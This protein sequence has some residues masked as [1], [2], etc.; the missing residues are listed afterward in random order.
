MTESILP[1]RRWRE[2]V[3]SASKGDVTEFVMSCPALA[4]IQRSV[5]L[6]I[7]SQKS[8]P[9]LVHL[10]ALHT[11]SLYA[12]AMRVLAVN[13]PAECVDSFDGYLEWATSRDLLHNLI[14]AGNDPC[15]LPSSTA[16][17]KRNGIEIE[18]S[19]EDKFQSQE[20]IDREINFSEQSLVGSGDE[21]I[22]T[23]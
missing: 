9:E 7:E 15:G 18:D 5:V 2:E 12:V 14:V 22:E 23:N 8:S 11:R 17:E 21:I 6:E 13:I 10:G 20:T 4:E 3:M 1:I 16:L 19:I